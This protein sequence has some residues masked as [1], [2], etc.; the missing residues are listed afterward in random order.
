MNTNQG[1]YETKE[2]DKATELIIP[3]KSELKQKKK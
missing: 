1:V 2:D 3:K